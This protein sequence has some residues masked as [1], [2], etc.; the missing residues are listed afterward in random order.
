MESYQYYDKSWSL[1]YP[2]EWF[3][4]VSEPTLVVHVEEGH[5][6]P[7]AGGEER[8]EPANQEVDLLVT[9]GV[10]QKDVHNQNIV[11]VESLRL[12]ILSRDH[13]L[14][15]YDLKEH[16]VEHGGPAVLQQ[17]P[18]ELTGGRRVPRRRRERRL[19]VR[20]GDSLVM[21]SLS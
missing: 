6:G 15:V 4:V 8:G 20:P 14:V 19:S 2:V 16:P 21:R 5:A 12:T 11:K 9:A 3:V 13:L 18:G 10:G 7:E 1:R 17:D